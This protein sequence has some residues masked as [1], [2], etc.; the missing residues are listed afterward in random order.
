MGIRPLRPS[1]YK[2]TER[3]QNANPHEF[4]RN[5]HQGLRNI[6]L[7]SAAR[8]QPPVN[9]RGLGP[10]GLRNISFRVHLECNPPWIHENQAPSRLRGGGLCTVSAQNGYMR[11]PRPPQPQGRWADCAAADCVLFQHRAPPK[12]MQMH[13]YVVLV[14]VFFDVF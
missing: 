9:S 7:Q 6:K 5:K 4:T 3:C 2:A 1:K 12:T 14:V 11:L 8:T 13:T 10:S